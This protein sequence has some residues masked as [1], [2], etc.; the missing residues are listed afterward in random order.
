MNRHVLTRPFAPIRGR[1]RRAFAFVV[2]FIC[3]FIYAF[4]LRLFVRSSSRS[5]SST[6][7]RCARGRR[8][9]SMPSNVLSFIRRCASDDDLRRRVHARARE[10]QKKIINRT[11]ARTRERTNERTNELS[12]MPRVRSCRR[13]A[14]LGH[15]VGRSYGRSVIRSVGRSHGRSVNR[16]L[17][18][19]RPRG[20]IDERRVARIVRRRRSCDGETTSH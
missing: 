20:R 14:S 10:T 5:H 1:R 4:I 3:A 19:H 8:R 16:P 13:R 9:H 15:T 17:D 6:S 2:A 7:R 18:G 12:S 11:N